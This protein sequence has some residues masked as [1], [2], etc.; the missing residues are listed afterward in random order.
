M[1]VVADHL[2]ILEQHR[3]AAVRLQPVLVRVDHHG[4]GLG[5]GMERCR[6]HTV[7]AVV[8]DQPE[9]PAVSGVD[10]DAHPVPGA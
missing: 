10:V 8:G 3:T 9:E 5:D 6:G 2:R 1:L 4:V 7:R